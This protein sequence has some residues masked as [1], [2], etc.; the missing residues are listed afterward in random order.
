LVIVINRVQGWTALASC[1]ASAD[2][3][4]LA[5]HDSLQV[6][7]TM[8]IDLDITKERNWIQLRAYW[9]HIR[10]PCARCNGIIDYDGVRYRYVI[11]RV[12][13]ILI[14]RRQENPLALDVGHRIE[15]DIDRRRFYAPI[16]TQPEHA[17][18]NRRAGARYG[19]RKRA[20]VSAGN[21]S[22]LRTSRRW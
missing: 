3:C 10:G 13:G 9:R 18:C 4:I 15:A 14:R 21:R 11:M 12:N 5:R 1:V 8:S 7:L 2:F 22:I 20:I 6:G 16:D 19:N 17:Y